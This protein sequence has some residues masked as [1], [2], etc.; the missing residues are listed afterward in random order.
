MRG[1]D[2]FIDDYDNKHLT[3]TC[4]DCDTDDARMSG[5]ASVYR[6]KCLLLLTAY[7]CDVY[8]RQLLDRKAFGVDL[9]RRTSKHV[10]AIGLHI[11]S[12]SID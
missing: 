12:G 7:A 10:L 9:R 5:D 8:E 6:R 2:D 1:G 11:L 4:A 3:E